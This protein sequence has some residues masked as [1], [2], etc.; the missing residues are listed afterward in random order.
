MFILLAGMAVRCGDA[1]KRKTVKDGTQTDDSYLKEA[2]ESD[3]TRVLIDTTAA[4]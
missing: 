1:N 3:T 4:H 2:L